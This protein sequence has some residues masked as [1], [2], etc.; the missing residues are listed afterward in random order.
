ME[1]GDS[2][3]KNAETIPNSMIWEQ[4]SHKSTAQEF[5]GIGNITAT[6]TRLGGNITREHNDKAASGEYRIPK[7][8]N[9]PGGYGNLGV[10]AALILVAVISK[11]LAAGRS[12]VAK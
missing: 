9:K 2:Q 4:S 5:W 10:S 3:F 6:L 12:S 1:A 8:P 11:R 7:P